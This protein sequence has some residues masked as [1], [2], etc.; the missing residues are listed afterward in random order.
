MTDTP[1]LSQTVWHASE[2]FPLLPWL[3]GVLMG[4]LAVHFWWRGT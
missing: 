3:G 4:G 1:T 2:V